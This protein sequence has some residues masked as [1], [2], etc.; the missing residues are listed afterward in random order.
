LVNHV[1][2]VRK[3]EDVHLYGDD[4]VDA[5]VL[6]ATAA[7]VKSAEQRPL[8]LFAGREKSLSPNLISAWLITFL[9][10]RFHP[11]GYVAT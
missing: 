6:N 3:E 2:R 9:R 7:A 10:A 5:A 11:E 1:L 4:I 8:Q